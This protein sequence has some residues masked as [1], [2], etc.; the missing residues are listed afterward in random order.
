MRLTVPFHDND[1]K[2]RTLESIIEQADLT[3]DEFT[4][5]LQSFTYFQAFR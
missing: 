3:N 2:R 5:L 4:D 1:L